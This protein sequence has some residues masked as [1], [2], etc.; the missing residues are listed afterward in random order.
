MPHVR[1]IKTGK[2]IGKK[3]ILFHCLLCNKGFMQLESQ[4]HKFCSRECSFKSRTKYP[5]NWTCK[6]C[7]ISF[8]KDRSSSVT[9]INIIKSLI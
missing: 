6:I 5:T 7:N 2:F 8:P 4:S 1:D 3:E 9:I